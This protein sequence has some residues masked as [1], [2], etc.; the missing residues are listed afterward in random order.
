[1]WKFP[2]RQVCTCY[3]VA[4][5]DSIKCQVLRAEIKFPG[6]REQTL[7]AGSSLPLPGPLPPCPGTSGTTGVGRR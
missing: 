1:M 3:N 4:I 7:V 6:T 5:H 2:L